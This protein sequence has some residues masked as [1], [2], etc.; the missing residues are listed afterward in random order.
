MM[1]HMVEDVKVPG[2]ALLT[3]A[4]LYP[5][6]LVTKARLAEILGPPITEGI[7]TGWVNKRLWPG[8][9]VRVGRYVLLNLE[10]A[11]QI[12]ADRVRP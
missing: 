6:P 11:R 5:S 3:S 1:P 9:T 8:G 10:A 2:D 12:C 4:V 7:V